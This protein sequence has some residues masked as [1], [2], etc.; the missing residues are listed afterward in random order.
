MS[1]P[2]TAVVVLS[3]SAS[4]VGDAGLTLNVGAVASAAAP[5]M[6][7]KPSAY[8]LFAVIAPVAPVFGVTPVPPVAE[9]FWSMK[10]V[11]SAPVSAT[12]MIFAA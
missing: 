4:V 9:S 6:M 12:T 5:C 2:F 10:V 1:A 3:A 8:S 11:V 7:M